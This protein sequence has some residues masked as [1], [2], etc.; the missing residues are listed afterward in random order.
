MVAI[1]LA[2]FL[3]ACGITPEPLTDDETEERIDTDL[4]EMFSNQES[5]RRPITLH[6][7]MARAL[8]YNL[9]NRLKVMEEALANKQLD[10]AKWDMLPDLIV[11]AAVDDRSNTNASSSR[12]VETQTE[13]L[14]TST[15]VEKTVRT[16]QLR[17]SWNI[18]DFGVS[19]F[20]AKQN[21]D[22]V[23]V[24]LERRRKVV[25]NI[26]QDV[27][28]AYWRA[29]AAEKLMRRLDPMIE[30]VQRA[31]EESRSVEAQRLRSPLDALTYQAALLDTIRELQIVRR[32]LVG[33]KVELAGVMNLPLD[34][35][36]QIT[37]PEDDTSEI[38]DL[39]LDLRTL[40]RMALSYRPELREEDYQ[41]RISADE[42]RK[43]I[44][45]LLPGVEVEWAYNYDSNDFLLNDNWASSAARVTW[46]LFNVLRGPDDIEAAEA[47]VDVVAARRMAL[48]MA[49]L[50]QLYVSMSDFMQAREALR[51]RAELA[52]VNT[53]IL[54]QLEANESATGELPVIRGEVD[55]LLSDL[56]RDFAYAEAQNALGRVFVS[57]GADPLPEQV[58][59]VDLSSLEGT[60]RE[61]EKGWFQGRFF[62]QR[63]GAADPFADLVAAEEPEDP[64]TGGLPTLGEE[65][66]HTLIAAPAVVE[67]ASDGDFLPVES[68]AARLEARE[69]CTFAS[70]YAFFGASCPQPEDE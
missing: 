63:Y 23:L 69:D 46:N 18:L 62:L 45:R 65:V 34:Q 44:L 35:E 40:E 61:T 36:F 58:A 2:V 25:H 16:A 24:A 48:S 43:S 33:A 14:E 4:A 39:E 6:M 32:D 1:C 15:S 28:D 8:S 70:L 42:V 41:T 51:I 11:S 22:R 57:V 26:I 52:D 56:R 37:V 20:A 7:A 60:L 64:E 55:A 67:P 68:R 50:T 54:A 27:R 13:S 10:V 12:S 31:L 3:A 38:P 19:Y 5:V 66:G 59:A 53:R 17:F 21:A 9:D 30:R 47:R 29:V 49:V